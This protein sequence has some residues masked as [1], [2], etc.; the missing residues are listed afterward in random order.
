MEKDYLN[1]V[2]HTLMI[3]DFIGSSGEQ[4]YSLADI[5][6][7][8]GLSK[9]TVFRNLQVLSK[10][11]YLEKNPKTS[12][13]RIGTKIVDLASSRINLLEIKT[14]SLPVLLVLQ[15]RTNANVTLYVLS[16]TDVLSVSVIRSSNII[17]Q[18]ESYAYQRS[19]AYCSSLGKCLLSGLSGNELA[20]LFKDYEFIKYTDNTTSSFEELKKELG[21]IREQG[22]AINY[23]EKESYTRSVAVPIYGYNGNVIAAIGLGM[24]KDFFSEERLYN[25]YLPELKV[26]SE[27]I[28]RKMGF[29]S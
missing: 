22:Y 23:G 29:S 21:I 13:Y 8:T 26:A 4:W 11:D 9:S 17:I 7:G 28:S 19:P 27:T 25:Q 16:G 1:S 24:T 18:D 10:Y 15:G 20:N 14:E 2:V 6:K 12:L 3:M 5:Q